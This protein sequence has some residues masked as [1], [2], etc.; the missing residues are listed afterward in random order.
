MNIL[1]RKLS[2][3]HQWVDQNTCKVIQIGVST[4]LSTINKMGIW[5]Q[6][7]TTYPWTKTQLWLSTLVI[8]YVVNATFPTNP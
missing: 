1:L 6:S 2:I 8:S 5:D 4:T 3:D 7:F